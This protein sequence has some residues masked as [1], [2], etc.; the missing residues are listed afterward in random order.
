MVVQSQTHSCT[1]RPRLG[2]DRA[3]MKFDLEEKREGD[4]DRKV[5][6]KEFISRRGSQ[7]VQ[8]YP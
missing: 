2:T 3:I 7:R 8:Q 4:I 6:V 5:K 1:A